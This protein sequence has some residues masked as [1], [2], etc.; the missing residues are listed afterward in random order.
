MPPKPNKA[1][2]DLLGTKELARKLGIST[3]CLRELVKQGKVPPPWKLNRRIHRW[4][5]R[6]VDEFIMAGVSPPAP[7]Q[8][9]GAIPPTPAYAMLCLNPSSWPQVW[10]ARSLAGRP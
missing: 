2:D 6:L 5:P 1:T 9:E 7:S 8:K 3:R 4:H 10:L